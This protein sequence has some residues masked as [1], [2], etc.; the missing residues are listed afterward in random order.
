MEQNQNKRAEALVALNVVRE[1]DTVAIHP[2][3]Y[4][5]PTIRTRPLQFWRP[6]SLKEQSQEFNLGVIKVTNKQ[7]LQT[8]GN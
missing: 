4:K 5:L 7:Y 6:W 3:V 1:L 2:P 8:R